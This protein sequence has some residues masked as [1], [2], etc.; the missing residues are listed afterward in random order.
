MCEEAWRTE[1]FGLLLV[2]LRLRDMMSIGKRDVASCQKDW[3]I[4]CYLDTDTISMGTRVPHAVVSIGFCAG[5][6]HWKSLWQKRDSV[7]I[8]AN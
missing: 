5:Q 7:R 8:M 3:K 2:C 6:R 4:G 1:T